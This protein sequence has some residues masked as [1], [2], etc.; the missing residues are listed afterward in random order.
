MI[1]LT[2]K[3]MLNAAVYSQTVLTAAISQISFFFYLNF[4][5]VHI[6]K[7]KHTDTHTPTPTKKKKKSFIS[8][9]LNFFL[10]PIKTLHMKWF[11]WGFTSLSTL[12]RSYHDG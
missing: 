8:K 10:K 3:S 12:Y 9:I 4:F 1:W 5:C 7:Q 6:E 2:C 11:I